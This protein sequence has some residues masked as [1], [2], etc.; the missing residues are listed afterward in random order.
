MSPITTH[1]GHT[2]LAGVIGWPVSHSLSPRI[3]G[4]WLKELGIDGAYV[5][6]PVKP[7]Q[8]E[9]AIKGLVALGV[10]G[11]NVTVPHK[12]AVIPMMD[13]LDRTARRLGAV[14][15]IVVEPSGRL[16]GRNSDGYGFLENLNANAP[17]W[18]A[19]LAP[20]WFSAQ[21]ARRG[22]SSARCSMPGCRKCGS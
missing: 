9:E 8:I 12:E 17:D 5:P 18:S 16:I 11:A 13:D 6:F 2:R 21:A 20:P 14:N 4:Y 10:A 22:R 19:E 1:T 15:T 7:G 3:H